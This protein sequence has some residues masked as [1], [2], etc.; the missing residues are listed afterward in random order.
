[1]DMSGQSVNRLFKAFDY[2][3]MYMLVT[4]AFGF[5]MLC[6]AFESF[7][8]LPYKKELNVHSSYIFKIFGQHME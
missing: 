3:S 5:A 8:H 1:M 2:Y 4:N 7:C 6:N